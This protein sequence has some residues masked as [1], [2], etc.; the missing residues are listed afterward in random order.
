MHK[1]KPKRIEAKLAAI[2]TVCL[3]EE[4]PGADSEEDAPMQMSV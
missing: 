2:L 1:A 4:D 3:A